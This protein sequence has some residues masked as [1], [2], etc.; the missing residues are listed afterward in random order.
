MNSTREGEYALILQ[1]YIPPF[2]IVLGTIS[3]ILTIIAV[4][5]PNSKK[6]SFTVYITALA[7]VDFLVLYSLALGVWLNRALK[8]KVN[9]SARLMCKLYHFAV[10]FLPQMSAWLVM[11]LTIERAICVNMK[12]MIGTIPSARVGAIVVGSMACFLFAVN[13]HILYG[14][15]FIETSNGTVC[16]FVDKSYGSFYLNYWGKVHFCLYFML[17]ASVILIGKHYHRHQNGKKQ[18]SPN[19]SFVKPD[20]TKD[21]ASVPHH[22]TDKHSLSCVGYSSAPV[23]LRHPS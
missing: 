15:D 3:N 12:K 18:Q 13:S 17:P 21:T 6:I 2:L 7:V 22:F 1:I 10:I 16:D 9:R 4:N 23:E 20:E 8:I 19:V 14:R 5:G 11:C